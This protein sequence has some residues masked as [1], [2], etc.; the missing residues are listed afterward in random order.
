MLK[1]NENFTLFS[2]PNGSLLRRQPGA[3]VLVVVVIGLMYMAY[4][5]GCRHKIFIPAEDKAL[6]HDRAS[7]LV[8]TPG[9]H[10]QGGKTTELCF[11]CLL[12]LFQIVF[13]QANLAE[14]M[15]VMSI[16]KRADI[17]LQ[18]FTIKWKTAWKWRRVSNVLTLAHLGQ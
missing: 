18:D 12:F 6:P 9:E 8:I 15:H 4:P 5:D 1:R 16:V 3:Q 2:D 7:T 13:L 10:D 17:E 11:F 14:G